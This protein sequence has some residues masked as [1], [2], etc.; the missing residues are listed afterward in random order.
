MTRRMRQWHVLMSRY[1]HDLRASLDTLSHW[2]ATARNMVRAYIDEEPGDEQS[3]RARR[4]DWLVSRQRAWG[5]PIPIV[6]CG[7]CGTVPVPDRDLPVVLPRDLDWCL[8]ARALVSCAA[9]ATVDCPVCRRRARRETDTLDCFFDGVWSWLACLAPLDGEPPLTHA[10]LAPWLPL[11]WFHSGFDTFFD[12]HLRRFLGR[13]LYS[14][15]AVDDPEVIRGHFGHAMVLASGRKMSKHLGNMIGARAVTEQYG[16]DAVR[17]AILAPA[18]PQRPVSWEPTAVAEACAFLAR[19]ARLVT[20]WVDAEHAPSKS[21]ATP[22]RA[23]LATS[24]RVRAALDETSAFYAS[25]RPNAALHA[26]TRALADLEDFA[27]KRISARRVVAADREP[28]TETLAAFVVAL[29]PCAPHLAEEMWARLGQHG[30]ACRALW[31]VEGR[32]VAAP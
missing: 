14:R 2:S 18:G 23:A 12:L 11:D 1:E 31:P 3:P 9:F 26:L 22:S 6:H 32:C 27:Y 13:F 10:R 19:I 21:A 28:I 7:A 16:A 15:G 25:Y 20:S 4:H 5:T 8:G 24:Q 29:A 30:L 17:V